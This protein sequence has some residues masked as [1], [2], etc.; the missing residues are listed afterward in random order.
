MKKTLQI[1]TKITFAV[2]AFIGLSNSVKAQCLPGEVAVS[3]DVI[4]DQWGYEAYW[5][6][7]PTGAGCGAASVIFAGGNTNVGCL[8]GGAQAAA[9]TDPG[10]YPNSM[11][12]T[13]GPFCLTIGNQYDIIMVDDWGDGST[14]ITSVAQNVNVTAAGAND[15]FTFTAIAPVA[16]DL[17]VLNST[18]VEY[19]FTPQSQIPTGGYPLSAAVR[20]NG[21][22]VVADAVLNVNVYLAPSTTPLQSFSSL[23]QAINAGATS[24]I[25]AGSFTPTATGTYTFE[26]YPS[27]VT[28]TDGNSSNDTIQLPVAVTDSVYA[29]DNSNV[30]GTLGL[31]DGQGGE[32]GQNYMVVNQDT[33]T[34]VDVFIGNQSDGMNNHPLSVAIYSTTAGTPNVIIATTDTITVDT[35]SNFMWRL[36]INGGNLILNSGEY[37]FVIFETDTNITVGTATDIFTTGKVWVRSTAITGGNWTNVETFGSAFARSLVIRPIFGSDMSTSIGELTTNNFKVYPNPTS[38]L[39]FIDEL[40]IGSS[41][42]IVNTLGQ[43]VYSLNSSNNNRLSI[44]VANFERGAYIINITNNGLNNSST[45]IKE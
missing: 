34:A 20:N 3:F 39:L 21:T 33:L 8:G 38:S 25:S 15:V 27:S 36:P 13:E 30:T 32:L 16:E 11:T 4:T 24:T 44:N 26:Y 14:Q 12:T 43:V 31:G 45:F 7:A 1:L 41:I 5:E 22:G 40:T 35:T 17:A 19:T 28:I 23:P 10:A 6:L 9:G 18:G 37:A 42:S 2:F 29:R